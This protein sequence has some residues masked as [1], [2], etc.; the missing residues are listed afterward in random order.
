MINWRWRMDNNDIMECI[1]LMC[2]TLP[3]LRKALNL[4]QEDFSKIIG[5][6][7]QSV[8]NMEHKEK[9]L[10]RSIVISMVS[11]FSLRKETAEILFQCELYNNTFVKNIGFSE[12]VILKIHEWSK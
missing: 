10:T 6:S 5:V 12:S 1:E 8:I 7:R 3:R 9:K 2:D 4:T 11:F